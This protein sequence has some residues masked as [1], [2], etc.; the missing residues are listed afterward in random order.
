MHGR[1]LLAA[2]CLECAGAYN[3]SIVGMEREGLLDDPSYLAQ[4]EQNDVLLRHENVFPFSTSLAAFEVRQ[5]AALVLGPIHNL[6]DQNYHFVTGA[7]DKEPERG[8]DSKCLF[9]SLVG[10]ADSLV[11]PVSRDPAAEKSREA[12]MQVKN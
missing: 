6:G 11:R 3:A 1:S 5:L 10:T 7:L 2:G 4:L 8:C 9:T 12:R